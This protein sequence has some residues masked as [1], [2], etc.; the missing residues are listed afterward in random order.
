VINCKHE[1]CFIPVEGILAT[2][3]PTATQNVT[4][5]SNSTLPSSSLRELINRSN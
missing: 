3:A 5:R 2:R 1:I 4:W